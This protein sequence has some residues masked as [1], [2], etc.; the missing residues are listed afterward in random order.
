LGKLIDIKGA[1]MNFF[2]M[3]FLCMLLTASWN[4]SAQVAKYFLFSLEVGD[5]SCD[6]H[7]KNE[8]FLVIS[9]FSS[10]EISKIFAEI[11]KKHKLAMEHEFNEY[12]DSLL[13]YDRL[14]ILRAL[15]PD[16]LLTEDDDGVG[17]SEEL[18]LFF[19]A[20]DLAKLFLNLVNLESPGRPVVEF[21]NVGAE[22]QG[23]FVSDATLH[24]GGYGLF[25]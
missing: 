18:E 3:F 11:N 21:F 15:L 24:I 17:V 1:P 13:D 10:Q 16:I 7:C 5:A 6:G 20:E 9:R 25:E 4:A 8:K 23:R 2:K 14:K 22:R 12:E 19:T